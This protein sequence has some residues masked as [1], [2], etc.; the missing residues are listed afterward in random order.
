MNRK[1][2]EKTLTIEE[3]RGIHLTGQTVQPTRNLFGQVRAHTSMEKNQPDTKTLK[4][5]FQPYLNNG[6]P[7]SYISF[8][9][10]DMDSVVNNR[11]TSQEHSQGSSDHIQQINQDNP[12]GHHEPV[13]TKSSGNVDYEDQSKEILPSSKVLPTP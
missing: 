1:L 9:N 5:V 6:L 11:R 12:A 2:A 7:S 13:D 3:W 8:A 10:R 4:L